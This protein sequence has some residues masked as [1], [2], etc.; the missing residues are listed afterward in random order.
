M[1]SE[2]ILHIIIPKLLR[3]NQGTPK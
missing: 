2:D 3:G 1:M